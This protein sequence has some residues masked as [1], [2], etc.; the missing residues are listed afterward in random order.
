[1][2]IPGFEI[3][4]VI[5][6]SAPRVIYRARRL[7][8]GA[9]VA[10]KTLAQ[11]YPTIQ[12]VTEIRREFSIARRLSSIEAVI[13]VDELLPHGEGNVAIVMELFGRSL[14]DLLV[15]RKR[16]GLSPLEF[17]PLASRIAT[18]LGEVH[19]RDIVHKDVVPRN[20][21]IDDAGELRLIDFGISSEL[22]Q[23]RQGLAISRRLEGSLPYISPEQT[24]RMNRVLD[25]RSDYYSLGVTY[26]ELLTG[27]LPFSAD[28][29]LEW[30]H[31]H[32]SQEPPSPRSL[33]TAIPEVLSR[34]VLKLIAK[35]AEQRY[36][37]TYGLVADLKRCQRELD[38]SG[39][40]Q[41]FALAERDISRRFQLPQKLYGRDR[42]LA[43]LR[44]SFARVDAGAAELCVV[45][46]HSGVGKSALVNELS[47]A[48]AMERGYLIQG[49]FDQ[50]Q[51]RAAYSAISQAFSELVRQ[52]LAEPP[53]RLDSWRAT[54][55]AT[56]GPNAQVIVDLVP[57]LALIIGDPPAATE[58]PATEAQNRLLLVFQSFVKVFATAE[59]PLVVFI[60]DLQWSDPP[61]LALIARLVGAREISHLLLIGAYRQNEVDVAHPLALTLDELRKVKPPT[62]LSL[63]PLSREAID[64]LTA[65]VL[66]MPQEASAA[67][68]RTR[69]TA[70]L[71]KLL[72]AKSAGNPFVVNAL[73]ESLHTDGAISFDPQRGRW[74]WRLEAVRRANVGD[75]VVDFMVA[76]LRKLAPATQ[77]VLQLAACIGNVFDLRTLAIIAEREREEIADEL[78]PALKRNMVVPL[79]ESYRLFGHSALPD[80]L[81]LPAH[82][83]SAQQGSLTAAEGANPRYRFQHDRV[84]QAAYALIDGDRKQAVHLS[85]GRLIQDNSDDSEQAERL[86]DIV[87]HLNLGRG[88]LD[89]LDER[90]R[91][92]ELNLR[93][94]VKA[95]GSS[96]YRSALEFLRMARE[97]LAADGWESDY[98][99]ALA[100]NSEYQ[101]CAYLTGAY[102][103]A[104]AC[105]EALLDRARTQLEKAEILATRTR[106]YS[107][108]GK[109]RESIEAAIVGLSLL[110]IEISS[111]PDKATIDREAAEVSRLLGGRDIAELIHAAPL[112]DPKA[113]VAIRLLME[114]FPAAFLSG[115]GNLFPFLV[116][117]SVNISLAYG[118]SSE[119]AFAYAAY[120][121]LLCG[122]AG[123]HALGYEYGKLAVRMNE[124]LED[125]KLK[126]RV[127]YVYTMF[128]H[129]WSNHYSTMTPWFKKGIEAGY[130][131]GDLLYLAYS[132]QDCII[133]DPTLDLENA[134]SEQRKY[135]TIVRDCE[136]QDSLD[137]GILF[138]QMLLNF[139]GKTAELL[140]MDDLDGEGDFDEAAC[141]AGMRERR[142]MTG[143]ANFH[144]YK[145]EICIFYH[146]IDEA[147][148]HV[149][150][151]D[152]LIASAMSLPQ[153]VRFY[154]VAFL[155]R[156]A[157]YPE[158]DDSDKQSTWR[159][160]QS[161]LEQMT[162]WASHCPEN[163]LH[164]RL[165][166]EAE[167]AR[168]E[169]RREQALDGYD[170]AIDAA[171]ASGYRRDEA[172]ANELAGRFLIDAGCRKAAEGYLRAAHYLY[173][174][175]GA[176]RKG[177]DPPS[178]LVD[179]EGWKRLRGALQKPRL[180]A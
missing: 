60:D 129:H 102:D 137:S 7:S 14:A 108:M 172:Q 86:I 77:R 84:Q 18:T 138:L 40:V 156:A 162:A 139:Q 52:V 128:V 11:R 96:S 136:Y 133:W 143:I 141:V 50:Y 41:P 110:D 171:R 155:T 54:L 36:Q 43:E 179:P 106:Q 81:H 176:N 48:I 103:E 12:D 109:M 55:T 151:Q 180:M 6:E 83:S 164:L 100:I 178:S 142:F 105:F 135:L 158:L 71:S 161:D 132:A 98:A 16:R 21:L 95:H 72:Y 170:A 30:V 9:A 56:L 38:D 93:A 123:E 22:S 47:N 120:G 92:A 87:S 148:E 89:D 145:A 68:P 166:M 165:L 46:G 122:A 58:L 101:Q 45:S 177:A 144:I 39:W 97:L 82:P 157:R 111:S 44:A 51:Q 90:R 13:R 85:I 154:I 117:K 49:K 28:N 73:L 17:L 91:L 146:A 37:S 131:S 160:L 27:E 80:S 2:E 3:E 140:S 152:E 126:S 5:H 66:H 31:R 175:W 74:R 57:E 104:A 33:D 65:D 34:I 70:A 113:R 4:E 8:D 20:I 125:I 26:F 69:P 119:S 173:Y 112:T 53:E 79:D 115:S 134:A 127:I 59:H 114:I 116:L 62:E 35:N 121:M 124:E 118:T 75:N 24:G 32:I 25:Y 64:E 169:D 88:L 147:Y 15:E 78:L 42:E 174:R 167:L 94:G 19:E 150:A 153:L 163:F 29:V 76:N 63:R 61:T 107:T 67:S 159:R 23:E 1:M 99:L 10:L 149:L 130:Q 168:L